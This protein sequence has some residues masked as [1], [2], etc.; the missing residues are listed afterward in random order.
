MIKARLTKI[1]STHNNLRTDTIE[2]EALMPPT[3]GKSFLITGQPLTK[4]GNVR[5][6][7]TTEVKSVTHIDGGIQFETQNSTYKYE[8]I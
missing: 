1:Q 7:H 3:V 2:G 4:D 6:V 8:Q 5:V